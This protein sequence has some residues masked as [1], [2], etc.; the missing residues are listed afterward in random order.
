MFKGQISSQDFKDAMNNAEYTY[1]VSPE[2]IDITTDFMRK[3]GVGRMSKPPK[4]SEWVKLDLLQ[5]AKADLGI[6]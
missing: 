3:Y 2:Y 1:D 4:A 6:K 5:K